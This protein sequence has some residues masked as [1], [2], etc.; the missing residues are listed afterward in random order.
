MVDQGRMDLKNVSKLLDTLCYQM[1]MRD[2]IVQSTTD[3]HLT[4]TYVH[5]WD[6]PTSMVTLVPMS[7]YQIAP[8]L[9]MEA[10]FE[11]ASQAVVPAL[12]LSVY[13]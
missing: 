12:V 13:F 2:G 7:P 1:N 3:K 4:G 5:L 8:H 9:E 10:L 6:P 11:T